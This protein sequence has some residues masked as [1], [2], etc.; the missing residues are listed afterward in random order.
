M[1]EEETELLADRLEKLLRKAKITIQSRNRSEE[2]STI[3]EFSC[4]YN[5]GL[6][7][8][9]DSGEI[10]YLIERGGDSTFSNKKCLEIREDQFD[11]VVKEIKGGRDNEKS[12]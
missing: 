4:G 7:E 3:I 8:L 9:Y 11:A 2:P 12:N 1:S 5:Q 10:I 6:I